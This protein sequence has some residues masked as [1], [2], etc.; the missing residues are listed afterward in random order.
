MAVRALRG[1]TT[2]DA[3]HP[4][5]VHK[6]T[7]ELLEALFAR[8]DV[9]ADDIISVFFTTT[10]DVRSVA[11]AAAARAFGLTDVPLICAQ[12]MPVDGSLERCVRLLLHLDT[13]RPRDELRHVF[14]RGATVLRPDLAEPG[15][16]A[17]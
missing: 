10:G 13:D 2:V 9:G 11:P 12:E 17:R 6:R 5:E 3:D 14:L 15:D 8:N 7:T 16:E 4:D 1:A